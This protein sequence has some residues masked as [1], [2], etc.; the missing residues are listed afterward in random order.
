ILPE[1]NKNDLEEI[2]AD[3]R[4][5]I[6]FHLVKKMEDVLELALDTPIGPS[7]N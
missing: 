3:I 7:C 6:S 4:E 5:S 1:R 2:P